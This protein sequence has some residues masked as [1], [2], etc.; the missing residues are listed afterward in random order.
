MYLADLLILNPAED[1]MSQRQLAD[2]IS[3]RLHHRP[4]QIEPF[5]DGYRRHAR[6]WCDPLPQ[7]RD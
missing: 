7:G 1:S 4:V 5:P 6:R 2:E 3:L